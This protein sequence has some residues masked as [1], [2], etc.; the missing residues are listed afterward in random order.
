MAQ[1]LLWHKYTCYFGTQCKAFIRV[2][3]T[4]DVD[5]CSS[6]E[7]RTLGMELHAAVKD[8]SLDVDTKLCHSHDVHPPCPSWINKYSKNSLLKP[9]LLK[10]YSSTLHPHI[11]ADVISL[12]RFIRTILGKWHLS[13]F[14][15]TIFLE[16]ENFKKDRLRQVWL[17]MQ[18][19]DNK[20]S[21]TLSLH[22]HFAVSVHD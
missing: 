3:S 5:D 15:K 11:R 12:C 18:H 1:S 6:A 20:K 9:F 17:C 14:L 4:G 21:A 19:W 7:R 8:K 16:R 2:M 13:F 10:T 22:L